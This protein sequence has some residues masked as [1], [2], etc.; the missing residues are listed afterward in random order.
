MDLGV[1]N[2]IS[3]LFNWD[4]IE[5]YWLWTGL[6]LKWFESRSVLIRLNVFLLNFI[7]LWARVWMVVCLYMVL[8][9]TG[10]LSRMSLHFSHSNCWTWAPAHR[11]LKKENVGKEAG[12][13]DGWGW[14]C[15]WLVVGWWMYRWLVGCWMMVG[16][17]DLVAFRMLLTWIKFVIGVQSRPDSGLNRGLMIMTCFHLDWMCVMVF[18][19]QS[20]CLELYLSKNWVWL[21]LWLG[22]VRYI[23]MKLIQYR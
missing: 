7:K 13:M 19:S 4:L 9:W 1:L 20:S 8:W 14:V 6:W 15:V 5:L 12:W 23:L 10:D 18:S 16:C 2:L 3:D 17:R 22:S 21:Q 11:K